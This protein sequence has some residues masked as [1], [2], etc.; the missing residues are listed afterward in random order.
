MAL[1]WCGSA[2]AQSW[3]PSRP[4]EL[5]V[6]AAPGGSI[7]LTARL[8]QRLWDQHKLIPAPVI[9]VNERAAGQPRPI[10]IHHSG[11]HRIQCIQPL[12]THSQRCNHCI[13]RL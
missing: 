5:I 3:K 12:G 11:E 9:V 8:I 4:V 6:G 1:A 13:Q 2:A 10:Y 7:D